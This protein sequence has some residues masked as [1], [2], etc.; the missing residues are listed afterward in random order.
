MEAKAEYFE[1]VTIYF[2]DIVGFTVISALSTPM[3]MVSMLNE[4][5]R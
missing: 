5:F 4:L 2:S 3:Q 1:A